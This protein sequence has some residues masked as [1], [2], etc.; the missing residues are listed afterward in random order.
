[1]SFDNFSTETVEPIAE[2]FSTEPAFEEM[3]AAEAA[4]E[5]PAFED[6]ELES[7]EPVTEAPQSN[8]SDWGDFFSD[9]PAEA[10]AM[11]F[12]NFSIE[13]VEPIAETAQSNESDWGDFFSDSQAE[14]KQNGQAAEFND[15]FK[16]SASSSE[17][18][19]F[20]MFQA[21]E[22][23]D[24]SSETSSNGHF[25]LDEFDDLFGE[26]L[27]HANGNSLKTENQTEEKI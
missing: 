25:N 12:D 26:E 11:S 14:L 8:E 19:F 20:D 10:E 15:L 17:I 4:S 21:E 9:S 13:T 3:L 2:T 27:P 1:M 18:D 23:A 5:S 16:E 24:K 7:L 22:T 6:L